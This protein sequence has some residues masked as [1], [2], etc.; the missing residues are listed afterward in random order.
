MERAEVIDQ[1]KQKNAIF[2]NVQRCDKNRIILV[3]E[4]HT[5]L[6]ENDD[7]IQFDEILAFNDLFN[8]LF[9]QK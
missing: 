5:K 8:D 4:V 2:V 1:I 7:N 9:Y 3:I 6:G